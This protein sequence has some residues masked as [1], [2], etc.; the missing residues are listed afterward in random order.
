MYFW[1]GGGEMAINSYVLWTII[2]CGI[3]T[4]LSR[5]LPFVLVK[6]FTI[7]KPFIKFLSFVPVAIMTAL[8]VENILNFHQ[9]NW[10]TINWE[11]FYAAIPTVIA[12]VIS[13]SL[14]I[15]AIVGV[16]SMALVRAFM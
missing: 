9:G 15:T 1:N 3:V 10:P 2:G 4:W 5:V 6:E 12:V 13:R 7:P 11:S 16:I 14:L 8:F